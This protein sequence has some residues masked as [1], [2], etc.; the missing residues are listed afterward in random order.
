M[1]TLTM[2]PTLGDLLKYELNGSFCREAVTLKAGTNYTLGSV[3]GKIAPGARW[4]LPGGRRPCPQALR[5]P[6]QGPVHLSRGER[7]IHSQAPLVDGYRAVAP[8][9]TGRAIA[10]SDRAWASSSTPIAVPAP[11]RSRPRLAFSRWRMTALVGR[12]VE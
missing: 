2:S 9:R 3:L 8:V 4:S 12:V 1:P 11:C 6:G 7:A 5:Q 10:V